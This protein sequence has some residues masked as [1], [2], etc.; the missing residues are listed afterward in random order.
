MLWCL[1]LQHSNVFFIWH[2]KIKVVATSLTNVSCLVLDEEVFSWLKDVQLHHYLTLWSVTEI[3][4]THPVFS[5]AANGHITVAIVKFVGIVF[6]EYCM[7]QERV[8]CE[9]ISCAV[10]RFWLFLLSTRREYIFFG[11]DLSSLTAHFFCRRSVKFQYS[12]HYF[13]KFLRNKNTTLI[14]FS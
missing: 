5:L 6:F 13:Q 7:C 11:V 12:L 8:L 3:T 14:N 1:T 4:D 9:F 10:K 2:P